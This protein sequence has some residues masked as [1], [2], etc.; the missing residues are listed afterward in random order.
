MFL[1]E[2]ELRDLTGLKRPAAQFAWLR[3]NG[4]PVERDAAGRPRVLRAVVEARMGA[5]PLHQQAGPNWEA[6]G[7]QA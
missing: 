3:A 1:T 2:T 4:W 7:G 6:L 5:V